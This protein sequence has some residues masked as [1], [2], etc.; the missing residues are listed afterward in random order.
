MYV[1][2]VCLAVAVA[3]HSLSLWSIKKLSDIL[4]LSIFPYSEVDMTHASL[5]MFAA[6]CV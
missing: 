3:C 6:A 1:V 2:S 4:S 5:F